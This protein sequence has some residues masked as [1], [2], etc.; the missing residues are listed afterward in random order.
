MTDMA[1]FIFNILAVYTVA[2]TITNPHFLNP[3]EAVIAGIILG[4][5]WG[6]DIAKLAKAAN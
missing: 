6:L 5:I 3:A 4:I 2:C 1:T